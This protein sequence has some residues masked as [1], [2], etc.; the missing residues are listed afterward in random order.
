PHFYSELVASQNILTGLL[1]QSLRRPRH[2]FQIAIPSLQQKGIMYWT[3]SFQSIFP[4]KQ[5]RESEY[6][7]RGTLHREIPQRVFPDLFSDSESPAVFSLELPVP[8]GYTYHPIGPVPIAFE[9]SLVRG[10]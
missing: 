6:F 10:Q 9:D 3:T 4:Q 1:H 7:R 2:V 8:S 5:I